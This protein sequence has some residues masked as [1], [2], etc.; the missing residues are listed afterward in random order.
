MADQRIKSLSF[1]SKAK[2]IRNVLVLIKSHFSPLFLTGL[3]SLKRKSENEKQYDLLGAY[4]SFQRS[5][6][7]PNNI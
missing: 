2:F 4:F 3:A 7:H 5:T 6:E 1:K